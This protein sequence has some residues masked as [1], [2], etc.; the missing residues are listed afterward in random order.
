MSLALRACQLTRFE[1]PVLVG[2]LAAAYAEAGNFDLAIQTAQKARD[3]ALAAG[4]KAVAD[5]NEG[6]L[7][8]YKTGKP[9]RRE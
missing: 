7:A 9:F 1:K 3:L 2:T 8:L 5:K 6:L 4:N